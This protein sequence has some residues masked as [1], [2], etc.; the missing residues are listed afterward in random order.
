MR[1]YMKNI[2]N[3]FLIVVE[4]IK[5]KIRRKYILITAKKRSLLL[6]KKKFTIISNNCWGGFV[7]Q[8]YNLPYQTPT[9][10]MF[11]MA[12]DYIK[13]IT[14]IHKYLAIDKFEE[15]APENSK[16]Y[17]LLCNKPNFGRYPIAKLDD[18]E[19]HLLHY[20]SVDE[21]E[22]KW[23]Q[24]KKRIDFS[25]II[26][27]FSEMNDCEESDIVDFQNINYKNKICFISANYENI[28]NDYTIVVSRKVNNGLK[29]SCE[30][31]GNSKKI[32][33]NDFINGL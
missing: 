13:F 5:I 14:N 8:S 1:D 17:Q 2:V 25:N 15:V 11:F 22:K 28:K 30:P 27:K 16:W 21:A 4:T 10:G 31:I 24:R 9:I 19:L 20:S 7:Y 18:I 32:N 29:S 12:K 6:R 26:F 23:N 3:K 33:I